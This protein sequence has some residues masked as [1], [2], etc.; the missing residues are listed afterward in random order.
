MRP[1]L[2]MA[3]HSAPLPAQPSP[4]PSVTL[5]FWW[6][7]PSA[8][9]LAVPSARHPPPPDFM[10]LPPPCSVPGSDGTYFP[11]HSLWAAP[12][13]TVVVAVVLVARLCPTL[14]DPTDCSPPGSSVHRILQA[15]ILEWI[16]I[17]FSRG[18]S[19]LMG[20]TWV[21]CIAGRFS[22]VWATGKTFPLQ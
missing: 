18:S 17:P 5:A 12:P 15:R 20:Q 14:C 10:G 21:F 16:A 4:V 9:V 2:I 8:F 6:S 1:P 7:F 11:A 3:S 13:A 19:R 22:T